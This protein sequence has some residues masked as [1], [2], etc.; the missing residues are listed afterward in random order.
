MPKIRR[1][2]IENFRA[3]HAL[4]MD[5]TDLTVIVGDMR[6][7]GRAANLP[8]NE[9]NQNKKTRIDTMLSGFDLVKVP[10]LSNKECNSIWPI[11][12]L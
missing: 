3:I 12:A 11:E 10:Q 6:A 5:A 4:D 9:G 2:A 7:F 1:I 8:A